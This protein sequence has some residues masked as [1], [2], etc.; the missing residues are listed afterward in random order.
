MA[1]VRRC[2]PFHIAAASPFHISQ[3]AHRF[4]H[5]I[6]GY[7]RQCMSRMGLP[8]TPVMLL[9]VLPNKSKV[10]TLFDTEDQ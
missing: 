3:L 7:V 1:D 8:D 10:P 4:E 5:P 2:G 6:D 9:D